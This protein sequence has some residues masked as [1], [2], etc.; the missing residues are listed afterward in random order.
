[1]NKLVK[2]NRWNLIFP[3]NKKTCVFFGMTVS[4]IVISK[5]LQV[6]IGSEVFEQEIENSGYVLFF[7]LLDVMAILLLMLAF[8]KIINMLKE[9]KNSEKKLLQT[10]KL[11]SLGEMAAS[12][13]HEINN[14]L[15]IISGQVSRIEKSLVNELENDKRS[16][17]IIKI[18]KQIKRMTKIIEGLKSYSRNTNEDAFKLVSISRIINNSIDLVSEKM[19]ISIIDFQL[20]I[21]D[22]DAFIECNEIQIEQ[23]LVNLLNNSCDAISSLKARWINLDVSLNETNVE[24]TIKDSGG[25]IPHDISEKIMEPFYTTKEAGK[26]TGLGLSISKGIIENHEGEL[27]ID[28]ENKNTTFKIVLKKSISFDVAIKNHLAW[29]SRLEKYVTNPD[30]ALTEEEVCADN[31]CKLGMWIYSQEERYQNLS[32]WID[33]KDKHARFHQ[34]A[35]EVVRNANLGIRNFDFIQDDSVYTRKSVEAINAINIFKNKI[36]DI[37]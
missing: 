27:F 6:W 31:I 1:M 34:T 25:G 15:T 2:V 20:N 22:D 26:G 12:I 21:P 24:I 7:W 4:L 30:G 36:D 8:F 18:K 9:R 13:A 10:T 35:S 17:A 5:T 19:K 11:A 28:F 33:L 29:K 3:D 16:D 32:E 37:S 14:P 23:V